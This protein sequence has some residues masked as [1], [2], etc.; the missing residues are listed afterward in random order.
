MPPKT[1][2]QQFAAQSNVIAS[3]NYTD[4]AE[5][6]GYSVYYLIG[7]EDDSG[8]I[9]LLTPSSSTP[10]K[11]PGFSEATYQ[12][13][14]ITFNLPK[15]IEGYSYFSG[16]YNFTGDAGA[17]DSIKVVATLYHYD[18]TTETTIGT[19][20]T[21]AAQSSN[22]TFCLVFDVSQTRFKKGETLRLKVKLPDSNG[23]ISTDPS[24]TSPTTISSRLSI[25]FK[26]EEIGY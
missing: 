11:G 10:G 25:P 18:G 15:T 19:E 14:D 1:I 21:P 22:K 13:F 12:N 5:G 4:I 24:G 8:D 16:Q 2:P 7:G 9:Y 20:V 3:Y 26:L 6:T 17:G 23:T